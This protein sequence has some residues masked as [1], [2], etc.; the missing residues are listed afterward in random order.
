MTR[1]PEPRSRFA[2]L[3]HIRRTLLLGLLILVTLAL[4]LYV[5]SVARDDAL[6][7][8]V[9]AGDL[10][11]VQALCDEGANA[12]AMVAD[13]RSGAVDRLVRLFMLTAR[14]PDSTE[15]GTPVLLLSTGNDRTESY[16]VTVCLVR[17]G[18]DANALG[19]AGETPLLSAL[20][21]DKE[22]T[23][24]FL[25]CNGANPNYVQHLEGDADV[26]VWNAGSAI[27]RRS[28][29]LLSSLIAHG[30]NVNDRINVYRDTD[31]PPLFLAVSD[32]DGRG[33]VVCVAQLVRGGADIN[34]TSSDDETPL[35][36]A[37][38]VGNRA[39]AGY[40]VGRSADITYKNSSGYTCLTY[41]RWGHYAEWAG[42]F[43][44]AAGRR[45][46]RRRS[47]RG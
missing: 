42:L 37:I 38:S 1:S 19:P 36:R 47:R 2:G 10:A 43:D 9:R 5:K 27:W 44:R 22:R 33:S 11:R 40:L 12:N 4:T 7:A 8:A 39:A 21:E 15:P 34:A 6:I 26:H 28:P 35:M 16:E 14:P 41:A 46:G 17:H 25:L 18:A 30:A 13:Q 31:G 29:A 23:A 20:S 3:L 24:R 32:A 45:T